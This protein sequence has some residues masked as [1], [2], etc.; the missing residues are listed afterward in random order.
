MKTSEESKVNQCQRSSAKTSKEL[1]GDPVQERALSMV[2]LVILIL[3]PD[4]LCPFKRL[5]QQNI[6]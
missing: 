6:T 1:Q 5:L 2:C 4:I 3:S